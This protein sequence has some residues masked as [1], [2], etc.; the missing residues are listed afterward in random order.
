MD[1]GRKQAA[2]SKRRARDKDDLKELFEVDGYIRERLRR[3]DSV[4]VRLSRV[5]MLLRREL[6]DVHCFLAD[7]DNPIFLDTASFVGSQFIARIIVQR[8]L[9]DFNDQV[10][11]FGYWM[12]V[13]D[14][15]FVKNDVRLGF[16]EVLDADWLINRD[17]VA[18]FG[19]VD[20][21]VV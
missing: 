5:I 1:E 20:K 10:Y 13:L 18:F 21:D 8:G 7:I 16:V 15:H 2:E 12:P 3:N 14:P 19:F 9:R 11:V 6:I 17:L 4:R